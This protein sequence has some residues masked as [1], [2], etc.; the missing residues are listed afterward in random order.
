[1]RCARAGSRGPHAGRARAARWRRAGLGWALVLVVAAAAPGRAAIPEPDRVAEALAAANRASGRAEPLWFE[2]ALRIGDGDPVASGE[3]ASHP[4][5]LARL[6][7]RTPTG[8]VERHL[9][10]GNAYSAS[11]DGRM[12]ENPR[13][14]LP[15][16]FLL[17][18]TSGA[19]L[20]AALQSFGVPASRGALGRVADHDCYVLGGRRLP[21]PEPELRAFP[22][23]PVAAESVP[24]PPALWVDLESLDVVRI[25]A[26]GG[27]R[28][29]LGPVAAFDDIRAPRW[30]AI[31]APGQPRA[32]LDILRVAPASAPA[33]AFG[34]DWLTAP[35]TP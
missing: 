24:G 17:Q 31:E 15:P 12:L 28:F 2:V 29:L 27:V 19:A 1:M 30:I 21:G 7:L 3:L 11:R 6:E 9:L 16:V 18:A 14:F 13:P 10:Q 26:E 25:D 20:R 35:P 4:T 33:A 8:L 34:T 5:G 23:D 22:V 32:R